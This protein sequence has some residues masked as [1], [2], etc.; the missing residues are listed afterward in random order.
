MQ[1][2]LQAQI[3]FVQDVYSAEYNLQKSV[4]VETEMEMKAQNKTGF[5]ILQDYKYGVPK[6]I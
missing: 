5:W 3:Q 1:L 4:E 6:R 2:C